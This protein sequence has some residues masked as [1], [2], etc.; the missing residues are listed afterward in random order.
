TG[1]AQVDCYNYYGPTECTVDALGCRLAGD[2]PVIGRPLRN[3]R[4]YVLDSAMRPVPVGVPGE[5]YLAGP[6]VARGYLNRPGLTAQRFVA[7]PFAAPGERMYRTGDLV[8]WT[9]DGVLAYLGRVDQ[10]V[11]IRGFRIEPGE[12]EAALVRH[13]S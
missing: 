12:I 7:D 1:S 5:L 10:Q 4:V 3:L 6:Q 2:R 13:P 8:R 11:K 9:A